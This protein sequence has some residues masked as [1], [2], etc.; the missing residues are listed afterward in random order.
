M[1]GK[2]KYVLAS[3]LCLYFA[4]L[5]L[6]F[7]APADTQAVPLPLKSSVLLT[8][9]ANAPGSGGGSFE[10][11][12][13]VCINDYDQIV[14]N[15]TISNGLTQGGI[16]LLSES[17]LTPL[18]V[19]GQSIDEV[20]G[21]FNG[22]RSPMINSAGDVLFFATIKGGKSRSGL[23]LYR[24][25]SIKHI[26]LEG[27]VLP[28]TTHP[29]LGI[30]DYSLDRSGRVSF[31]A[32]I[33]SDDYGNT[34]AIYFYG[35]NGALGAL[36]L[37]GQRDNSNNLIIHPSGVSYNGSSDNG[38]FIGSRQGPFGIVVTGAA[39]YKY[40][41]IGPDLFMYE[42]VSGGVSTTGKMHYSRPS[43]ASDGYI[44]FLGPDP[45]TPD[46]MS[47][48]TGDTYASL[49]ARLQQ[50]AIH[51]PSGRSFDAFTGIQVNSRHSAL[52]SAT[53]KDDK[54]DPIYRYSNGLFMLTTSSLFTLELERFASVV[55][56][57]NGVVV[58][59][60]YSIN[61]NDSLVY[62]ASYGQAR[63]NALVMWR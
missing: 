24:N 12:G 27:D 1:S 28:G 50:G 8:S 53:M 63:Q 52:I 15:T 4:I 44:G 10:S 13:Q 19:S 54:A 39:L 40:S 55:N 26:W 6:R 48:F 16:Y 43:I 46:A 62:I 33:F 37:P 9:G 35:D 36:A 11:F 17:I 45:A 2:L 30:I 47:V 5:F 31:S 60:S 41:H 7:S 32:N 56:S 23:F 42:A 29:S 25:K 34:S 58:I 51:A 61:N 3:V 22:F 49:S 14:F 57:A 18:V 21:S 59:G 38:A 20:G